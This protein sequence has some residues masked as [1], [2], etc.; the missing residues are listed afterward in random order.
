MPMF[1]SS[2][3]CHIQTSLKKRD[4]NITWRFPCTFSPVEAL[5]TDTQEYTLLV[6]NLEQTPIA[7]AGVPTSV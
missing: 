2:L 3:K 4:H 6:N 5:K 7:A 1:N